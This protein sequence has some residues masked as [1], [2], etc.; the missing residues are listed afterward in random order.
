MVETALQEPKATAALG[1]VVGSRSVASLWNGLLL[2]G[3][4]LQCFPNADSRS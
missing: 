1:L 2:W 4:Q 3:M